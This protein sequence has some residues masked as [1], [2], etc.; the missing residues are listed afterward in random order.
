MSQGTWVAQSV[1]QPVLDLSPDLDLKD[2][3]LSPALGSMMG[4]KPTREKKKK[5]KKL[6]YTHFK[7]STGKQIQTAAFQP[8]YQHYRRPTGFHSFRR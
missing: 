1:K 7:H 4:M 8:G 2:M 3:S 6:P 5:K